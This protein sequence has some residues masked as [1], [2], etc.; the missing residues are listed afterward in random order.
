M[1][2]KLLP[3][4]VITNQKHGYQSYMFYLFFSRYS[5]ESYL[6]DGGTKSGG[7]SETHA[8]GKFEFRPIDWGQEQGRSEILFIGNTTDFPAEVIPKARFDLLNGEE[9]MLAVGEER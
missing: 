1:I 3:Q 5:P 6:R 4:I 9:A 7:Y 8:I 2:K